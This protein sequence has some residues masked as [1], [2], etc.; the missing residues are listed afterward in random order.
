MCVRV[1]V[2]EC[3][4]RGFEVPE[5]VEE[6]TGEESEEARFE[7]PEIQEVMCVTAA[8]LPIMSTKGFS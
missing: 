5:V 6:D 1:C 7:P 4:L 2:R 3:R 8:V